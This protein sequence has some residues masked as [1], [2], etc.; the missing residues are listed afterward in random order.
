VVE[1]ELAEP[2]PGLPAG[3]APDGRAYGSATVLAR[4]YTEPLALVE[5]PLPGAGL[6]PGALATA[7]WHTLRCPLS[8]R[9]AAEGED[10]PDTLPPGGLRL[11]APPP[12]LRPGAETAGKAPPVSV[13]VCTRDRAEALARCLDGVEAQAYPDFE[14]LVVD[15]APESGAVAALLAARRPAVPLRRVVEQRPG[16]ARARNT[17]RAAAAG[18]IVA[19]LDDDE[20]PDAHWLA[21]TARGFRS[22][23]GVACVSGVVLPAVLDTPA[24]RWFERFGGHSK[25]RGFAEAVFDPASHARQH[26][27]YPL[28][29]FGVG[30]NMAFDPHALDEIGGFDVTLG[31]GTPVPGGEDSAAIC[32]LM[33]SG[34]TAVYRPSA[35]MWHWHREELA[36]L[37]TQ[38]HG[39]GAGLTA[40]YARALL[41]DPRVLPTLLRLTPQALHDLRGQDSVRTATMGDDYPAELTRAHR[42]GM[43][44]GPARYLRSRHEQ[45]PAGKRSTSGWKP[46]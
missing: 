16:L 19:Y 29:P 40:F 7:L 32:D 20:R 15:N 4:W 45:A 46:R 9:L 41:H 8:E 1:V 44:S 5:I 2:T 17:G 37:A 25:G 11:R 28:P 43:L 31:A 12:Q 14:I 36:E 33:L 26:P 10:V 42:R 38:L 18:K 39:Y 13:I 21:E 6:E 35:L 34:A 27:L 30:A 23:P 24:Q 22:A 3:R